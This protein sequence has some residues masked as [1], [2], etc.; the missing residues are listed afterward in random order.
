MVPEG[1][2]QLVTMTITGTGILTAEN[3]GTTLSFTP[4]VSPSVYVPFAT[5]TILLLWPEL[6]EAMEKKLER[7]EAARIRI[8]KFKVNTR[9][10]TSPFV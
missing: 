9:L 7:M 2:T 5:E 4:G 10:D 1:E 8:L 6:R 3:R